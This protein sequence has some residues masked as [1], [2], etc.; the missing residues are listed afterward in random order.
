MEKVRREMT[1][2]KPKADIIITVLF[3]ELAIT[4]ALN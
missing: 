2:D 4:I 1:S 3:L